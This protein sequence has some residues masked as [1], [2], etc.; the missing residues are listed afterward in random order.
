MSNSNQLAALSKGNKTGVKPESGGPIG[1]HN[2]YRRTGKSPTPENTGA[3]GK[4][5]T[6]KTY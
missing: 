1:G 3:A 4:A 6:P 5:T 2:E